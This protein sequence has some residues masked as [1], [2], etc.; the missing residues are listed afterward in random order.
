MNLYL[1]QATM[2]N[3][4]VLIERLVRSWRVRVSLACTLLL[5]S[6]WAFFPHIAYRI[7]PV[8]FVNAELMRVT[9]PI[10]G[11]LA[12][13]LPRKGDTIDHATTVNLVDT[14]SPDRRH[15][16]ELEQQIAVAKDRAELAKR[17]LDEIASFDRELEVRTN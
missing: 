1:Q 14:L 11:R 16:L 10:A 12:Q 13:D 7:A 9:A 5:A 6:C 4:S 17:Q 2:S 15:L 8:A 3:L